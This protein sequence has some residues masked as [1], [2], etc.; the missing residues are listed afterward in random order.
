MGQGLKNGFAEVVMR[1]PGRYEI[2]LFHLLQ[3]D[4]ASTSQNSLPLLPALPHEILQPIQSLLPSLL[5]NPDGMKLIHLSLLIATLGSTDQAWHADGP[6]ATSSDSADTLPCHVFNIFIPLQDTPHEMGPTELRPGSHHLTK[7]N[8]AKNMLV[9]K[10]RKTLRTTEWPEL[11]LGDVL[12]FDYRIL[13][14]GRA[15][16]LETS[17][18]YLVMTFAEPW[19]QDKLNFPKRSM[20]DTKKANE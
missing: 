19:F 10:C 9:A 11:E 12:I 20:Y 15:N 1:S 14:R 7:G 18:N 4:E 8:L 5:G 6:H 3:E 2:S 17:R 16:N 13:H